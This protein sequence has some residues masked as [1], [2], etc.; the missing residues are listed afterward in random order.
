[1]N[2]KIKPVDALS[3]TDL[4]QCPVW[5]FADGKGA[6]ET[7]VEPVSEIPVTDLAGMIV[8]S[9]VTLNNGR[10]IWGTLGNITVDS[11]IQ[12]KHLITISVTNSAKWFTLARYHDF[13][14]KDMGP[15]AMARFLE[16]TV[17]DIFPISYDIRDCAIG[18]P[19]ALAGSIP[20]LP[21]ERLTRA[22]LIALSIRC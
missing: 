15:A 2:S 19:A 9:L 3:V 6:D 11:E 13:D 14:F 21:Q 8:G 4:Q 20:E 1:M 12:T 7:F 18:E 22:E 16:M 5:R 17:R 10:R